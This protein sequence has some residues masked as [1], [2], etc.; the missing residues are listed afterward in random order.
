MALCPSSLEN[1]P[2]V[3]YSFPVNLKYRNSV[4]FSGVQAGLLMAYSSS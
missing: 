4:A 3:G 2:A 1:I